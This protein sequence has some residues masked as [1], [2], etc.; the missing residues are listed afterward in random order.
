[1]H[2]HGSAEEGYANTQILTNREVEKLAES[3]LVCFWSEKCKD[4]L[5]E[6]LEA[7]G[8]VEPG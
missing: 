5:V 7:G 6:M 8:G 2:R 1:M 3:F 4:S